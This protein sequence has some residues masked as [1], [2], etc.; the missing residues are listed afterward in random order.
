MRRFPAKSHR[1]YRL[2]LIGAA[3]CIFIGASLT[4]LAAST[5]PSKED[6]RRVAM[7]REGDAQRGKEL[8]QA[9]QKTA[10][11]RCHSVD[12]TATKAGPDLFAVGDKFTRRDLIDAVIDPSS[13]IAVGCGGTV[14]ALKDGEECPDILAG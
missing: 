8:F 3:G 12:G 5:P 13:V 7:L 6:Y 1:G 2:V 9:E 11:S 14:V 4:V 10:C